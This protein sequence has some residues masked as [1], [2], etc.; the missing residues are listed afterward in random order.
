M[1]YCALVALQAACDRRGYD[2]ERAK[3]CITRE[4]SKGWVEVDETHAE[5]PRK[6]PEHMVG[7]GSQLK[8]ILAGW[9]FIATPDCPCTRRANIMNENGIQWCIDNKELICGW[10]AEEARKRGV[11]FANRAASYVVNK[12]IR[13]A[14]EAE[15]HV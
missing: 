13:R 2:F 11:P 12:A 7:V 4:V 5:Y 6:R 15:R 8:E 3:A 10:L 14:Q 1:I 9:G